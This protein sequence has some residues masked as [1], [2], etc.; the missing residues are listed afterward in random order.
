MKEYGTR[1]QGMNKLKTCPH[2]GGEA[3]VI[4]TK[5]NSYKVLCETDG[6][7]N[8]AVKVTYLTPET[9]IAAWNKR[10]TEEQK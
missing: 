1:S 10:V 4:S 8:C 7:V 9:A 5:N 2:C 3:F 6:C